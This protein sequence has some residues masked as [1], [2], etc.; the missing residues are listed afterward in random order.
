[1]LRETICKTQTYWA[2]VFLLLPTEKHKVLVKL[3]KYTGGYISGFFLL[4]VLLFFCLFFSEAQR[5]QENWFPIHGTDVMKKK[6]CLSHNPSIKATVTSHVLPTQ[7]WDDFMTLS[8]LAT[9][10]FTLTRDTFLQIHFIIYRHTFGLFEW[11]S[12]VNF[13]PTITFLNFLSGNM[14]LVRQDQR[15]TNF[16]ES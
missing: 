6:H 3:Q 16:R 15:E 1:M 13:H 9:S 14:L 8:T 2:H 5:V 4:F 7:P 12:N 11:V 10:K